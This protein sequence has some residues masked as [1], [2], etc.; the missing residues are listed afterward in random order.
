MRPADTAAI[1][2]RLV[3]PLVRIDARRPAAWI[4]LAVAGGGSLWLP[5]AGAGPLAAAVGGLLAVAAIGH[6]PGGGGLVMHGAWAVPPA[7]RVLW[8]VAGALLAAVWLG[9]SG[10]MGAAVTAVGLAGSAAVTAAVFMAFRRRGEIEAVAASQSLAIVGV[11]AAAG[12]AVMVAGGSPLAQGAAIVAAW[13][14]TAISHLGGPTHDRPTSLGDGHHRRPLAGFGAVMASALAGMTGCYFLSPQ[15][16]W[17]YSLIAVGWF[18]AVAVPAATP[19]A[20]RAAT[21]RLVRSAAGRPAVP[22]SP[23]RA[24]SLVATTVMLLAWPAVVAA[25][26]AGPEAWRIGGPLTALAALGTAAGLTL[27]TAAIAARFPAPRSLGELARAVLLSA[28][29]VAAI[30]TAMRSQKPPLSPGLPSVSTTD[31]RRALQNG[32]EACAASCQTS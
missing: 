13:G 27:I 2:V 1:A 4:A 15:Y 18:V 22:A 20:G 28:A 14:L 29:A 11:S 23:P 5:A 3:P 8:P 9:L 21:A 26:L 6:L 19:P 7:V 17:A 10:G 32:V 16:A 30:G 25:V 31:G 12:V 24:L